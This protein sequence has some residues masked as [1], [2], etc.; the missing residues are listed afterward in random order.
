MSVEAFSVIDLPASN[1]VVLGFDVD[2]T[3]IRMRRDAH[4]GD[5]ELDEL[6]EKIEDAKA[7]RE[8]MPQ[9]N[10]LKD[11]IVTGNTLDSILELTEG[12]S[13]FGRFW[14][15]TDFAITAVGTAIHYRLHDSNVLQPDKNWP[16]VKDWDVV[17][18]RRL[19]GTRF[20]TTL[21]L[22]PQKNQTPFKLSYHGD[23]EVVHELRT[24][25]SEIAAPAA[26]TYSTAGE[27]LGFIDVLPVGVDKGSAL[28][29]AAKVMVRKYAPNSAKKPVII[30]AGDSGNDRKQL[31]V[32]DWALVPGNVRDGLREWIEADPEMSLKTYFA[33]RQRAAG[34][35]EGLVALGAVCLRQ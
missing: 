9:P 6:T 17:T 11:G 25:L 4:L 22:Q 24:M 26:V 30:A 8:K 20:K 13:Y 18:L 29:R 23:G 5:E 14:P 33:E 2:G 3:L 10:Y 1:P 35:L 12:N 15:V 34:V 31:Q 27:G 28:L 21:P 32:A 16:K 7:A 19:I